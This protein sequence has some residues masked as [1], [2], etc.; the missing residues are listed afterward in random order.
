MI[1]RFSPLW[2]KVIDGFGIH[3]P[4]RGRYEQQRSL[5]DVLHPGRGF[6]EKLKAGKLTEQQILE[7]VRKATADITPPGS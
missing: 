2:N 1:E 4:G 3:D 5:W 6:A 7:R